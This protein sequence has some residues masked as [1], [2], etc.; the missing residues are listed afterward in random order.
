MQAQAA[1]NYD[2]EGGVIEYTGFKFTIVKLAERLY[3][4]VDQVT[5]K[6]REVEHDY[7]DAIQTLTVLD[8]RAG[9]EDFDNEDCD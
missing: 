6:V 3:V 1:Q 9:W 4:I 5:R 2:I 8:Q 7:N